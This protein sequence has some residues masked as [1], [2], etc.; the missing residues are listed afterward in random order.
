[1][2][3]PAERH[4]AQSSQR[5]NESSQPAAHSV[6][7]PEWGVLRVVKERKRKG[8]GKGKGKEKERKRKGKGK[9]REGIRNLG[10]NSSFNGS[11]KS[12][13]RVRNTAH[14]ETTLHSETTT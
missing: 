9:E 1:M 10:F 3:D 11:E 12:S 5:V 6:V 7:V 4:R 14:S 8:K 2:F 13:Q